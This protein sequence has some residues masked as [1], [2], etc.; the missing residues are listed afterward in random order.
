M[1]GKDATVNAFADALV[2]AL[3]LPI[4][5]KF[6]NVNVLT[7]LQTSAQVNVVKDAALQAAASLIVQSIFNM[8]LATQAR[9]SAAVAAIL[10]NISPFRIIVRGVGF[11]PLKVSGAEFGPLKVTAAEFAPLAIECEDFD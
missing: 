3:H 1:L 8:S 10:S 5:F 7:D 6:A 11:V 2:E 4:E 9:M